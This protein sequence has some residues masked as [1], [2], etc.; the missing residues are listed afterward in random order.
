[1]RE[2]QVAYQDLGMMSYAEA[3]SRQG[4]LQQALIADKRAGIVSP[5]HLLFCEH[6][7]VYTL[8]RSG[9]KDH[10]LIDTDS[11]EEFEFFKI[12][13][14]GDITYH[15]PGQL[16][17]YPIF[18]LDRFFTDVHRYVRHLEEAVIRTLT[19]F[20]IKTKR[21]EG[22]TGVWIDVPEGV[23]ERKI[24]AIG[25]HLSRWVT[26][27]GL[28]LNVDPDLAHFK[29]IIPCGIHDAGKTVTSMSQELGTAIDINEVKVQLR[30][31]FMD[32]FG[33]IE[34]EL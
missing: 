5:H 28:A 19:H 8:G 12:N 15:G 27:H 11:T 34:V 30:L 6:H 24:C 17:V 2:E 10:L 1:M 22:F 20:E 23:Q 16:T 33:Y 29:H 14:G 26:L 18:D 25:V 13:R 32:L 21:I 9:S 7:P 31:E 4:S 3:W